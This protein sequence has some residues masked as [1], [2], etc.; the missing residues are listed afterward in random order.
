MLIRMLIPML[1]RAQQVTDV[2][3]QILSQISS[4]ATANV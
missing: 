1:T 2:I 3:D 4:F